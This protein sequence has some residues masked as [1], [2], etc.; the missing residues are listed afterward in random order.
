MGNPLDWRIMPVRETFDPPI[1][2]VVFRIINEHQGDYMDL[3]HK[4]KEV[5]GE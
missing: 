2:D 4:L 5:F 3:L 1:E